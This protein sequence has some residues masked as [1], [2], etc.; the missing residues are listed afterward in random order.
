MIALEDAVEIIPAKLIEKS[1]LA[2]LLS[3]SN[4]E[5]LA[6]LDAGIDQ[7]IAALTDRNF[8]FH[9][10]ESKV[11]LDPGELDALEQL[12]RQWL[13]DDLRSRVSQVDRVEGGLLRRTGR[14]EQR[15]YP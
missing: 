10:D 3:G 2:F 12:M 8:D 11:V 15:R 9:V 4:L 1:D 14:A 5:V 13:T 7:I 6:E